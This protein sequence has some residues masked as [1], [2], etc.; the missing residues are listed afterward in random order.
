MK[1]KIRKFLPKFVYD[2]FRN[3]KRKI[4]LI[5]LY[6]MDMK[7][8]EKTISTSQN[9]KDIEYLR[10]RITYYYHS[11]EKGLS[12]PNIRLGFGQ[13]A[14]NGLFESLETYR[15]LGYP[16]ED[17]R[18][19]TG[20]SVMQEYIKVHEAYDYDVNKV[21]N[22][23]SKF[24]TETDEN[25]G[26]VKKIQNIKLKG[27]I[28]TDFSN[29]VK[30]RASVRTFSNE[31]V[32]IELIEKAISMSMKT[33]SVCNR[34]PWKAYIIKNKDLQL[35]VLNHQRGFKG[36]EASTDSLFVITSDNK[37]MLGVNER[38]QGYIDGG[39]FSMSLLYSLEYLG[40]AAC[41]LNAAL[42]PENDKTIRELVGI[43]YS[44]SIIMFIAVGN[45]P[46]NFSVPKSH[47]DNFQDITKV[48]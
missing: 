29:L 46:D 16:T 11:I 17:L 48:L 7:R 39:M 47:R 14:M 26:G 41:P 28:N 42:S 5:K 9:N 13:R 19:K 21:K 12:N 35:K 18:F 4:L 34:Q 22:R 45:F 38:N 32:D 15:A 23:F 44:E 30:N 1:K 43:P 3:Q 8:F 24:F 6:Y 2:L 33:P 31:A 10:A 27:D 20:I 36:Y 40:L 25:L 37:Y